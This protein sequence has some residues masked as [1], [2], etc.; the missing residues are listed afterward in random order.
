M[1][2]TE[3]D[4]DKVRG[5]VFDLYDQLSVEVSHEPPIPPPTKSSE[6]TTK[7]TEQIMTDG[8]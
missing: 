3:S 6:K 4:E 2:S 8:E 1:L 5:F 7:V